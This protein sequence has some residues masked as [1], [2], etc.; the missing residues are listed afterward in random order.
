MNSLPTLPIVHSRQEPETEPI[1]RLRGGLCKFGK[2][3]WHT[4]NSCV[5]RCALPGTLFLRTAIPA[6]KRLAAQSNNTI[7]SLA[8]TAMDI[9][10]KAVSEPAGTL[11]SGFLLVR[12][13]RESLPNQS[14][15]LPL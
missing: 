7:S 12:L 10:A 6:G 2:F 8:Q 3:T 5:R 1:G 9:D 4:T 11:G 14:R 15:L 13:S